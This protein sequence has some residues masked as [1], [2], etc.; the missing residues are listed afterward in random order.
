MFSADET[1]KEPSE[2]KPT[3]TKEEQP[4][5]EEN[6]EQPS[7]KPI[8]NQLIPDTAWCVVW[9]GDDKV[10]YFNPTTKIS[11][12]DKPE[13]LVGNEKLDKILEAGPP[14]KT[15]SKVTDC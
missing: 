12:W 14:N 4:K 1:S 2:E 8:A 3:E 15:Q 7:N 5:T 11:I 9:T 13:E 6:T 10:F